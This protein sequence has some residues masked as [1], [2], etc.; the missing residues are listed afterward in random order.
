MTS[1]LAQKVTR[2]EAT[3]NSYHEHILKSIIGEKAVEH[4]IIM[5]TSISDNLQIKINGGVSSTGLA[6]TI[7]NV[8][9]SCLCILDNN[10]DINIIIFTLSLV[11]LTGVDMLIIFNTLT[12]AKTSLIDTAGYMELLKKIQELTY[13]LLI[14][15][16]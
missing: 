12:T 8:H 7:N 15:M 10:S 14:T 16:T 11:D 9:R 13:A 4:G 5:I 2:F 3:D 1:I 6:A